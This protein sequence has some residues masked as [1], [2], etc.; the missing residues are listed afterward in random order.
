MKGFLSS[1]P[2]VCVALSLVCT[3][4]WSS[5][6][7]QRTTES[8]RTVVES[9]AFLAAHPDL[10]FRIRGFELLNRKAPDKALTAFRKAALY[11]DK[12]SQAALA[13]MYW[14]GTGVARDRPLAY[15]WIDLAAERAYPDFVAMREKFWATMDETERVRALQQGAELYARY[16][17]DVAKPRLAKELRRERRKVV[18]SRTGYAANAK[19]RLPNLLA[20]A[21]DPNAQQPYIVIDGSQFYAEK[22]WE[23]E[24]YHAWL[25]A[26]WKAPREGKV[27]VGPIRPVKSRINPK[28]EKPAKP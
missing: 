10:L 27:E 3:F 18:G 26:Q 28:Q 6:H 7:A 24:T 2:I 23:P 21:A 12:P 9:G 16:G 14:D 1:R 17:D 11:G 22:F 4:A 19:V 13:G 15:A 20:G 8:E 5:A 25:D